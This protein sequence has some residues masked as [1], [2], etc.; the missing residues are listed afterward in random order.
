M[1]A[2][3]RR[4]PPHIQPIGYFDG[5]TNLS[6]RI[7]LQSVHLGLRESLI[8]IPRKVPSILNCR[9][10]FD[11]ISHS[12]IVVAPKILICVFLNKAIYEMFLTN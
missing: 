3:I 11:W 6:S 9:T 12:I 4:G 8:M 5:L 7:R 1:V 10:L 2:V